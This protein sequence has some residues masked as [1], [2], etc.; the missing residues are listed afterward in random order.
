MTIA[1]GV[2]AQ[3]LRE[4]RDGLLAVPEASIHHHFWGR[5]LT[6]RL[7][8][9]EY[10]NDFASW[11]FRGLGEKALA[12]RLSAI[13]PTEQEDGES[14]RQRLVEILEQTLDDHE[15]VPWAHSDQLFHFLRGKLVI[16]RTGTQIAHPSELP[17]ALAHMGTGSI[18]LHYID[19]QR[20]NPDHCDDFCLWLDSWG[21]DYEQLKM[22]LHELDPF[23]SSLKEIRRMLIETCA[24]NTPGGADLPAPMAPAPPA[25][26]TED[27]P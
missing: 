8:E 27:S 18:F 4:F 15:H 9:P 22:R 1:T 17:G 14:I 24:G 7:D 21:P 12:E 20:R 13:D 25:P 5:L 19:A 3:N 2:R 6:P 26:A 11:A 23:F 10:S 16:F